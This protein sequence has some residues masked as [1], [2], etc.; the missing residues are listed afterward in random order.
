MST[1]QPNSSSNQRDCELSV[2]TL[3]CLRD[4]DGQLTTEG[5]DS[6]HAMGAG[7]AQG[8]DLVVVPGDAIER[9]SDVRR[10]LKD[11]FLFGDWFK[12]LLFS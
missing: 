9:L 7:V 2:F 4:V 12:Q 10:S 3:C 1:L 8:C 6:H 11:H 5:V